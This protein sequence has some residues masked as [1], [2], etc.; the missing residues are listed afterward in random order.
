[1]SP[2]ISGSAKFHLLA[3]ALTEVVSV[4]IKSNTISREVADKLIK[5]VND[6]FDHFMTVNENY[7]DRMQKAETDAMAAVK[8]DH[9]AGDTL[10]ADFGLAPEE[11]ET[12]EDPDSPFLLATHAGKKGGKVS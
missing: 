12:E 8:E 5:A 1:M 9:K 11:D 10:Y 3:L 2:Y 4:A 6:R 7:L